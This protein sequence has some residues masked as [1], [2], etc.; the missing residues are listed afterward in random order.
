[1]GVG[2]G[3]LRSVV[4]VF[5]Y[6]RTHICSGRGILCIVYIGFRYPGAI[7][8]L[9]LFDFVLLFSLFYCSVCS[10]FLP[11]GGLING[12][13]RV[14]TLPDAVSVYLSPESL[15]NPCGRVSVIHHPAVT[16]ILQRISHAKG[17]TNQWPYPVSRS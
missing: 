16:V 2:E 11:L 12:D 5:D 10:A 4:V 17:L 13:R 9:L 6:L 8:S 7:N 1:M 3:E 14:P 15:L